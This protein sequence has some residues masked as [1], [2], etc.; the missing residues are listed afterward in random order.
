M[1]ACILVLRR[2]KTQIILTKQKTQTMVSHLSSTGVS[3][4]YGH[5]KDIRRYAMGGRGWKIHTTGEKHPA[6]VS[7]FSG[8]CRK[9]LL[10]ARL[11]KWPLRMGSWGKQWSCHTELQVALVTYTVDYLYDRAFARVAR[12]KKNELYG[13]LPHFKCQLIHSFLA[14]NIKFV[15][16]SQLL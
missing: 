9:A 4:A 1:L 11:A 6:I 5:L 10:E 16:L 2:S 14:Y 3:Y 13:R 12:K 7:N 15:L 8:E